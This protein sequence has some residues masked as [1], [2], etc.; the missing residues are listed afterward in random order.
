MDHQRHQSTRQ[1]SVTD[2]SPSSTPDTAEEITVRTGEEVNNV[3]IRYRAERGRTISGTVA[4]AP[5]E[6]LG[7]AAILNSVVSGGHTWNRHAT[8]V[9]SRAFAF[10]GIPD[11]DYYLTAMSDLKGG[12]RGLSGSKL[13]QVRGADVTGLE[14][15]TQPLASITGRVVLEDSKAPQCTEKSPPLF[16]EMSVSAWHRDNEANK[17][18]PQFVWSMGAPAT[19]NAQGTFRL[20]TLA[21]SQYYFQTRVTTKNWYLQSITFPAAQKAAKPVDATRVWTTVKAGDRLSGLTVTLAQGA[22]SFSGKLALAEGEL[23]T[24]C[25]ST[26]AMSLKKERLS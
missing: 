19:P 20:P 24:L 23:T 8:Q 10:D 3:D 17:N 9:G 4:E 25:V 2:D 6:E 11:R 15:T 16:T 12:E 18:T 1:K 21:P 22:A 7:F 13:I 5:G 26:Q 14:F